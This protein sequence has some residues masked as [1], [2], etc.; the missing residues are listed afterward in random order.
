LEF[1]A[2]KARRELNNLRAESNKRQQALNEAAAKEAEI[3]KR[4]GE[5]NASIKNL[6]EKRDELLKKGKLNAA[7][8][9]NLE[10]IR[11]ELT[12]ERNAKNN[13][14]KRLQTLSKQR[15]ETLKEIST[16][17]N[18][19]TRT[20]AR[21]EGLISTQE[22]SIAA[23]KKNLKARQNQ[24]GNLYR[25]I[26][27]LKTQA[28]RANEEIKR[29]TTKLATSASEINRLQGQLTKATKARESNIKNMQ[30]RHAENIRAATEQI[31]ALTKNVQE[32]NAIIQK[33][34]VAG[35]WQGAALGTQLRNTRTNLNRAQK[36]IGIARDVVTGLKGQRNALGTQLRNTQSSLQTALTNVDAK[37]FQ[38]MGQQSQITELQGQRNNLQKSKAASA[39]KGATRAWRANTRL[40]NAKGEVGRLGTQL[41]EKN[42]QIKFEQNWR[43]KAEKRALNAGKQRNNAM[44]MVRV[45]K[46]NRMKERIAT[47]RGL[48]GIRTT[49]EN[50][51]RKSR[52]QFNATGAFQNMGNKLAA[53]R[54]TWKRTTRT[55]WQGAKSGVKAQ[56]NLRIAK[57]TLRNHINSRRPNG[58]YTIGGRWGHVRRDLKSKLALVSNMNQLREIRKKVAAAKNEKN[59]EIARKRMNQ[60]IAKGGR[61]QVT[62]GGF[63]ASGRPAGYNRALNT[64]SK[65]SRQI[66]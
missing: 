35:R 32:R 3:T 65:T 6:T 26:E 57:N 66:I 58:E 60:V 41:K 55:R 25:E 13:E 7:E 38:I 33:S 48:K 16:K 24:V 59:T 46:A 15:E 28:T 23:N 39:W 61:E 20:L 36:E 50:R 14:I 27:A 37:Q 21:R 1:N 22:K 47:Q 18:V 12:A 49:L 64:R 19:A 9:E 34:K 29:Q 51:A 10:Q 63:A 5:S 56:E 11:K 43:G 17:L 30:M 62:F 40:R 4:L 31:Q 45:S 44:E 54:N 52:E 42:E 2:A 53:N 8:K